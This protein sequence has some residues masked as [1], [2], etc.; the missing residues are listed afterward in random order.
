MGFHIAHEIGTEHETSANFVLDADI[1]LQRTWSFVVGSEQSGPDVEARPGADLRANVGWIRGGQAE[2][3]VGLIR[4]FKCGKACCT[5]GDGI[6][7][8]VQACCWVGSNAD[9]SA[10]GSGNWKSA[11]K[12]TCNWGLQERASLQAQR[13]I[14]ENVVEDHI[15]EEEANAGANAGFA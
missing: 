5:L 14:E 11:A 10:R 8:E 13:P 2:G 1:H 7:A 6:S 12:Q 3:A 9:C 4:R 15:L